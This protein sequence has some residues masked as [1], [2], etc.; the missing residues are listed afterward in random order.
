MSA[1]YSSD[2]NNV[3]KINPDNLTPP[4]TSFIDTLHKR[5]FNTPLDSVITVLCAALLFYLLYKII[6]WAFLSSI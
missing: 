5:L 1:L 2:E 3:D 6:D 4:K